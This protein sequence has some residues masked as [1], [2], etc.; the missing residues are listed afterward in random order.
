M[1]GDKSM[2]ISN[3]HG[4]KLIKTNNKIFTSGYRES[5]SKPPFGDNVL[6]FKGKFYTPQTNEFPNIRIRFG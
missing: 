6:K 5:D 4:N 1:E 3:D 2:L